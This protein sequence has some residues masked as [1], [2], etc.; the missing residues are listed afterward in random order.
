M[1][2]RLQSVVLAKCSTTWWPMK[3]HPPVMMIFLRAMDRGTGMVDANSATHGRDVKH[4][5]QLEILEV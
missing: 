1:T 3:P 2:T 4:S 5:V